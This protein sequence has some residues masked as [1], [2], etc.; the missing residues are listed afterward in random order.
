MVSDHLGVNEWHGGRYWSLVQLTG[1]SWSYEVGAGRRGCCTYPLYCC[2]RLHRPAART[3]TERCR[4]ALDRTYRWP[5]RRSR[6]CQAAKASSR[7]TQVMAQGDTE[8]YPVIPSA[9]SPSW[10]QISLRPSCPTH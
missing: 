1:L 8:S 4:A 10:L 7:Q 3:E 6:S 2:R 9:W 5:V